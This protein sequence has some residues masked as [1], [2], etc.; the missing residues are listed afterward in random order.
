M[1]AFEARSQTSAQ[2]DH[3]WSDTLARLEDNLDSLVDDF[4]SRLRALEPNYFA[5]PEGDVQQTARDSLGA[6][7]TQLAGKPVPAHLRGLAARLGIRRARQG[8]DRDLLLEAV[9]LDYR[10]LW[11]GLA[12]ITAPEQASLLL[13]RAE[14]VLSTVESY[15]REVQV[16]FLNERDAL[17][18]TSR[19]NETRALTRLLSSEDAESAAAEVSD[20]LGVPEGGY[21]EICLIPTEHATEARRQSASLQ[22]TRRRFIVWDL[23]VGVLFIR[24]QSHHYQQHEF[25]DIPGVSITRIQGLS[26]VPAAVRGAQLLLPHLTGA[27]LQYDHELWIPF[28]ASV[29]HDK[30]HCLGSQ[31][32][33]GL[34]ALPKFEQERLI[35][36]FLGYCSTGS[37]K[38]TATA[39]F[40]HRNTVVNR[41]RTFQ[42]A[43][44]LDPTIPIEAARAL[45]LIGRN[46]SS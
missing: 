42:E 6:L 33:S 18:Q 7:I 44:G 39:T 10:V 2:Q 27:R 40:V 46:V 28:A 15:V 3:W 19:A 31:A 1:G 24:E 4:R 12:R 41:L 21:Y 17:A 23:D 36:N 20:L 30:L 32:L 22:S 35:T 29:L 43:T 45:I 14:E 34:D 25:A 11:A 5:V 9:R 16:A 13:E 37:I 8:V 38:D 26:S